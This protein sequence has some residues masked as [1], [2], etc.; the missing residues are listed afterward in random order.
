LKRKAESAGNR[1]DLYLNG[2]ATLIRL[3]CSRARDDEAFVA[4]SASTVSTIRSRLHRSPVLWDKQHKA[5]GGSLEIEWEGLAGS[6]RPAR[7]AE[8]DVA[9]AAGLE[10]PASPFDGM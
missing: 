1:V 2:S 5:T 7:A 3:P 6:T 4:S 9:Q 10:A 8:F